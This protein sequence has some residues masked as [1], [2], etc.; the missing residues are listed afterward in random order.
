MVEKSGPEAQV[1][2]IRLKTR[3]RYRAEEKIRIA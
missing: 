2:E 1:R 3:R